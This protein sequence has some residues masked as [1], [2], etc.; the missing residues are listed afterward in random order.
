MRD[1]PGRKGEGR[2]GALLGAA[3]RPHRS[4]A[5]ARASMTC[6]R[7][8]SGTV[9]SSRSISS[10][11]RAASISQERC[12]PRRSHWRSTAATRWGL[13]VTLNRSVSGWFHLPGH[14]DKCCTFGQGKSA[15]LIDRTSAP[16]ARHICLCG[17]GNRAVPTRSAP[18][19]ASSGFTW[20]NIVAQ[21]AK[22]LGRVGSRGRR[23]VCAAKGFICETT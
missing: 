20:S 18:I 23:E 17:K 8:R 14:C 1:N 13:R 22:S 5:R 2:S 6:W 19:R 15:A 21:Q 12:W 16:R 11:T 10:S 3:G 4:V 7:A 9:M